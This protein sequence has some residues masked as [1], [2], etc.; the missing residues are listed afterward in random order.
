MT[1]TE[2]GFLLESGKEILVN[3]GIIGISPEL[4]VFEG[5]DGDI[6][7]NGIVELD[8]ED[9]KEIALY[10]IAL[11]KRWG[12]AEMTSLR[13]AVTAMAYRGFR[14][15]ALPGLTVTGSRFS[16]VSKGKAWKGELPLR[17][18]AAL[19]D[20]GAKPFG[21][22]KPGTVQA[23]FKRVTT[24]LAKAGVIAHAYSVHDLRHFFAST[25]YAKD[26]DLVRV[27][28]LLNHA[29]VKVT[30]QYLSDLGAI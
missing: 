15:G 23:A 21:G 9:R 11:W 1:E 4:E 10:V 29:D 8:G 20:R 5:Y 6:D 24:R 12:G 3:R 26:H 27:S 17:V 16:T 22:V 19:R 25:E 18:R 7:P 14:V 30:T 2:L 28:R 13:A